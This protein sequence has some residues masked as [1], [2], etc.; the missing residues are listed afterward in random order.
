ML[1]YI[2]PATCPSSLTRLTVL[3]VSCKLV[4]AYGRYPDGA[5][6]E[7]PLAVEDNLNPECAQEGLCPAQPAQRV[8]VG[9]LA[10]QSD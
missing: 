9:S 4:L 3:T 10:S 8:R 2:R 6:S 1:V 7:P 5:R